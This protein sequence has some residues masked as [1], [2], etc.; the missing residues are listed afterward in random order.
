MKAVDVALI[1]QI[2]L[3]FV[4]LYNPNLRL[5]IFVKALLPLLILYERYH[6]N[7]DTTENTAN[8]GANATIPSSRRIFYQR[9]N[10]GNAFS[11]LP[12]KI[13]KKR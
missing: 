7:K 3:F 9:G 8:N 12:E 10:L 13:Q 6:Q 2:I 1:F 5:D 4:K 11:Y